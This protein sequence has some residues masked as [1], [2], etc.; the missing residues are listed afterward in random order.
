MD[1]FLLRT[2]YKSGNRLSFV[3]WVGLLWISR[4]YWYGGLLL[5]HNMKEF[6]IKR[7]GPSDQYG[8]CNN[9]LLNTGWIE[10]ETSMAVAM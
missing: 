9:D 8:H 3:N 4:S 7:R 1:Y 2:H 6:V 5:L 10:C